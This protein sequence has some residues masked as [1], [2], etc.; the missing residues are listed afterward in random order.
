MTTRLLI[1]LGVGPEAADAV[2]VRADGL[3]LASA[4]RVVGTARASLPRRPRAAD[5]GDALAA[6]ARQAAGGELSPV[7]AAGLLGHLPEGNVAERVAERTGLTVA[8]GFTDRDA[9]AGGTGT[10]V[11]P[12]ADFLLFRHPAEE[13]LLVHLGS[14]TSA[15]RLPASERVAD[16]AAFECGPGTRLLDD[17][18][19]L[20]TRGK[21]A[22][23]AGGTK[24]VQGH[25]DDDLLARWLAMP[26]LGR[27]PPRPVPALGPAFL[28]DAFAVA[29]ASHGTLHDLLCTATHF[30]ARC[31]GVGCERWLPSTPARVFVSGGGARN[32]FLWKL[33]ADQFP[34]RPLERLDTLG[35]PATAR[36]AAAAAVLA[37]LTLDG[38]AANLPHVTGASGSRLAGRFVPGDRRNWAACTAWMA[39]RLA[40]ASPLPRAA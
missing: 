30:V 7:L 5:A 40:D 29:R 39:G 37:G 24:A 35:V 8:S 38:V 4:P 21:E 31:V 27:E 1:G 22:H 16:V 36:T 12:L 11:T 14:V 19:A 3:G 18:T 34:G 25:C 23:D 13:R 17:L 6:A 9:A 28:T 2:A 26:F 33:L 32:G 15:V 10:L 20:G